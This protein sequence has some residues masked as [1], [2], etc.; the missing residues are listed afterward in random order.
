MRE[1]LDSV[2]TRAVPLEEIRRFGDPDRLLANVNTPAD[3]A[4]L[5][6]LQGHKL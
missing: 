3:Y 6:A 5:E 4:G 1:L 2:R